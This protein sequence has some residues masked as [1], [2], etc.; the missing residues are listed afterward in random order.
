MPGRFFDGRSETRELPRGISTG[1]RKHQPRTSGTDRGETPPSIG[2][3]RS[4]YTFRRLDGRPLASGQVA[5]RL[6]QLRGRPGQFPQGGAAQF[7]GEEV[8]HPQFEDRRRILRRQGLVLAEGQIG[9]HEIQKGEQRGGNHQVL[10]SGLG[11]GPL[12]H[13]GARK[14]SK[15]LH[16]GYGRRHPFA[17]AAVGAKTLGRAD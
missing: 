3:G 7:V 2:D 10:R 4:R 12:V 5:V 17:P 15:Q 11:L 13:A 9:E 16:F 8:A 14:G 6:R 1:R